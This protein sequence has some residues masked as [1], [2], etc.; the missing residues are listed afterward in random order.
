MANYILD[1][2][3]KRGTFVFPFGTSVWLRRNFSK[4][5]EVG[6]IPLKSS[7]F[8]KAQAVDMKFYWSRIQRSDKYQL[9]WL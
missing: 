3:L 6:L 2:V 4:N 7:I 1:I 8:E 5:H 9:L